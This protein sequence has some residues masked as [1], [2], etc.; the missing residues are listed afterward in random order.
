MPRGFKQKIKVGV[1]P[2]MVKGTSGGAG[3]VKMP[4]SKAMPFAQGKL[5]NEIPIVK[6]GRGQRKI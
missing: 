5:V 4:K 1:P 6:A 2:K 3:G